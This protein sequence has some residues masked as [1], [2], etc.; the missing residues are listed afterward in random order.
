LGKEII[1]KFQDLIGSFTKEE[2][3]QARTSDFWYSTSSSFSGRFTKVYFP[4][5]NGENI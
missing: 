4:R 2:T 3:Q 5:L 1:E